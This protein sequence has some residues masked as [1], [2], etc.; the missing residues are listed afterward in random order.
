MHQHA[1]TC[2]CCSCAWGPVHGARRSA[3]VHH[4]GWPSRHPSL[5]CTLTFAVLAPPV[6]PLGSQEAV[7]IAEP[8]HM[9]AKRE[10]RGQSMGS[11]PHG[12]N[13]D[14]LRNRNAIRWPPSACQPRSTA[15]ATFAAN[16]APDPS[17]LFLPRRAAALQGYICN[18][19][20]TFCYP[21][22]L[23]TVMRLPPSPPPTPSSHA[24]TA[25]RAVA[26]AVG[27]AECS[28][29][30]RARAQCMPPPPH[31]TAGIIQYP[32]ALTG[33]V[34]AESLGCCC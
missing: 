21:R 30:A 5:A 34:L 27:A 23:A 24:P 13:P 4:H 15:P 3:I 32:W 20:T 9:M 16:P 11:I 28:P 10:S 12:Q 1:W 29:S 19:A 31:I 17:F 7:G 22:D 25:C 14:S 6:A 8:L 33:V 18:N 26:C 2:A